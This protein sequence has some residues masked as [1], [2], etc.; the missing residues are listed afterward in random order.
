MAH[1]NN[2]SFASKES[3]TKLHNY[4][5]DND[6]DILHFKSPITATATATTTPTTTLAP[7]L[8]SPPTP[9]A[10]LNN[11]TVTLVILPVSFARHPFRQRATA[12]AGP[13]PLEQ[14]HIRPTATAVQ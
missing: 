4:T 6:S 7:H 12:A 2:L 5:A 10:I 14:R 1:F 11:I 8:A 3:S 9:L 13:K